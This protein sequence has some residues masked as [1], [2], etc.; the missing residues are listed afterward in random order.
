MVAGEPT[1]VSSSFGFQLSGHFSLKPEVTPGKVMLNLIKKAAL[2]AATEGGLRVEFSADLDLTDPLTRAVIEQA[3]AGTDSKNSSQLDTV[4]SDPAVAD[5]SALTVTV[6]QTFRTSNS[7][8]V[9]F[10]DGAGFKAGA[11]TATTNDALIAAFAKPPGTTDFAP[12]TACE[13]AKP[14]VKPTGSNG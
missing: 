6:Y 3:L 12:W 7:F 2:S 5:Q 1:D 9:E 11:G 4:F 10:G 13:Q 14:T 8:D